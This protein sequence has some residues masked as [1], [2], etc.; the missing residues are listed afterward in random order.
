M[1][2]ATSVH[3]GDKRLADRALQQ[4][5]DS[6]V[7]SQT[8]HH[9]PTVSGSAN[10]DAL[11][12]PATSVHAGDHR[13]A[14]FAPRH[15]HEPS[16]TATQTLLAAT[17]SGFTLPATVPSQSQHGDHMSI[18]RAQLPPIIHNP[19][20]PT[21]TRHDGRDAPV[22]SYPR[23]AHS[24]PA[25]YSVSHDP[26]PPTTSAVLVLLNHNGQPLPIPLPITQ[27]LPPNHHMLRS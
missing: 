18:L 1:L 22:L 17:C 16:L 15:M 25:P 21:P 8:S 12:A 13:L 26:Q 11:P 23:V 5:R 24:N 2:P 10:G 20:H 14:D 19:T 3:A 27:T 6:R 4:S 9:V 7:L